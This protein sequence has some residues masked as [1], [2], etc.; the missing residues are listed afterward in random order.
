MWT[1]K[2]RFP[3][4]HIIEKAA[5]CITAFLSRRLPQRVRLGH[6]AMSAPGSALPESGHGW[7]IYEY[8]TLATFRRK[9][10]GFMNFDQWRDAKRSPSEWP[11]GSAG[12]KIAGA[13]LWA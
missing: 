4:Y 1:L 6:S 12:R 3:P 2:E 11:T 10:G 13:D 5:L 7:T 8:Y 9:I